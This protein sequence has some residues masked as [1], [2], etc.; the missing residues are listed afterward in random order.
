MYALEGDP[1]NAAR[2]QAEIMAELA[3][4]QMAN[5]SASFGESDTNAW[6]NA[7][8]GAV[9]PSSSG[10][11][12]STFPGGAPSYSGPSG[13]SM[14]SAEFGP[15]Y[16]ALDQIIKNAQG[17]Y[18]TG[19]KEIGNMYSA[20]ASA[21]S[22]Q[23]GGIRQ[24]YDKTGQDIGAAYNDAIKSASGAYA[25]NFNQMAEIMSRLGLGQ[26]AGYSQQANQSELAKNLGYLTGNMTSRQG[27][28]AQAGQNALDFNRNTANNAQFAG[29]NKQAD[30]LRMFQ[31]IQEQ[32]ELKRLDL[33][34]GEVKSANSYNQA[35]QKQIADQQQQSID[36]WYKQQSLRQSDNNQ[37]LGWARLDLDKNQWE[38]G[39]GDA[40]AKAQQ[41]AQAQLLGGNDAYAIL[42]YL[43][44][45]MYNGD[46][47]AANSAI[48]RIVDT[49]K[50]QKGGNLQTFLGAVSNG[51]TDPIE[52]QRLQRLAQNW[53]TTVGNK[54]AYGQLS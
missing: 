27:F 13:E 30:L 42:G 50:M 52:A 43:G 25:G 6:L 18:D 16:A 8:G 15:Q 47:G 28:T 46:Q 41:Q 40:Q 2:R 7:N 19:N 5:P 34:S 24:Q 32:N 33:K 22:G 17:R 48:Q 45:Q 39:L 38:Q 49:Y 37:D 54:A 44:N 35:I 53:W 9:Q 51:I 31:G 26:A 29:K 14:A 1:A 21:I 10:T 4:R 23:E 36:N 20:L 11:D 12:W 3:A